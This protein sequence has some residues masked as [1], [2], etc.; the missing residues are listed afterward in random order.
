M[1]VVEVLVIIG[2]SVDRPNE[3]LQDIGPSVVRLAV[4]DVPDPVSE[5]TTK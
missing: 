1:A 5:D 2:P 4:N 3:H